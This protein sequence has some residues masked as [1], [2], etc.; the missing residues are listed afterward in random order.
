MGWLFSLMSI[1]EVNGGAKLPL[2][3]GGPEVLHADGVEVG[4]S[5]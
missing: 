4:S 5:A 1:P 2:D 3:L